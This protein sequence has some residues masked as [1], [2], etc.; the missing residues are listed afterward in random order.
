[1][2]A[3]GPARGAAARA[4]A[5]RPRRLRAAP[6]AASAVRGPDKEER[7][8]ACHSSKKGRGRTTRE[9]QARHAN[10]LTVANQTAVV[11]QPDGEGN[12]PATDDQRDGLKSKATR[13]TAIVM[14]VRGTAARA[15][16]VPAA[17]QVA[18]SA[19]CRTAS[20]LCPLRPFPAALQPPLI[21]ACLCECGR[22]GRGRAA[23]TS[24]RGR[25]STS[26]RTCRRRQRHCCA[27]GPTRT[28]TRT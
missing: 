15:V 13:R 21:T 12:D 10:K 14:H 9:N 17:R 23:A 3:E 19:L 24:S 25:W 18:P 27:G 28:D 11:A 8:R 7:P 4:P 22:R 20:F 1:M 5:S 26:G 2:L 6:E 16:K